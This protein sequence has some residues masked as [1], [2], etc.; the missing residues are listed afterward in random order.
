MPVLCNII[1]LGLRVFQRCVLMLLTAQLELC[2][3]CQP[4]ID[5]FS[6]FLWFWS[7]IKCL[8]MPQLCSYSSSKEL[9][10]KSI[11]ECRRQ[12][13]SQSAAGASGRTD[14]GDIKAV[15]LASGPTW[16]DWTGELTVGAGQQRSTGLDSAPSEQVWNKKQEEQDDLRRGMRQRERKGRGCSRK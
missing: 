4:F 15:T 5:L 16:A 6:L 14:T 1:F 10:L 3:T 8:T 12:C 2:L 11:E 9:A 7:H 13:S